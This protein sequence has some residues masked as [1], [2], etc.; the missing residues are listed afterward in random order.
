MAL[1]PVTWN[2]E[3]FGELDESRRITGDPYA[4]SDIQHWALGGA[5]PPEHGGGERRAIQRR[6]WQS[7]L[8]GIVPGELIGLDE[9][10]LHV[11]RNIEP[12][13]PGPPPRCQVQCVLEMIPD[14]GR[15]TTSAYLVMFRAIGMMSYSWS[16][17]WR[18]A[19]PRAHGGVM[20]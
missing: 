20:A 19:S 6:A 1:N 13:R 8:G 9:R 4:R 15:S 3:R 17:S 5:N 10:A 16:P 7:H 12:D 18:S 2:A 14:P 11:H